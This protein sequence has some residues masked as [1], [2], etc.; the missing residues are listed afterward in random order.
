MANSVNRYFEGLLVGGTLGFVFGLLTAPKAGSELRRELTEQTDELLKQTNGNW[1]EVK[2]KVT[3]RVQPLKAK[4]IEKTHDLRERIGEIK[5]K[6]GVK[7]GEI[8]EKVGGNKGADLLNN[9]MGNNS[10]PMYTAG[11]KASP[12]ASGT[13]MSDTCSNYNAGK[14]GE[15][16]AGG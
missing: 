14:A 1:I 4:A 12:D 3:E 10:G 7:M 9:Y 5:E 16:A 8:R 2:D 13:A 6:A 11:H 15:G